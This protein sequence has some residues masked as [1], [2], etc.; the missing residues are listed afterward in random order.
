MFTMT[1]SSSLISILQMIHDCDSSSISTI[2]TL[3]FKA[4]SSPDIFCGFDQIKAAVQPALTSA[5]DGDTILRTLDLFS[6]GT[7]KDAS[8]MQQTLT[9]AQLL[10]LRMLTV[11]TLVERACL[12]AHGIVPYST[13]AQ[14]LSLE[15]DTLES[16]RQIEELMIACIYAGI[17]NG[18]LCQKTRSLVLSSTDGPPCR[19]R[20]VQNVSSMLK[21]LKTIQQNLFSTATSMEL[22][23]VNV[24]KRREVHTEFLKR[25]KEASASG[26]ST[27]A[28]GIPRGRSAAASSSMRRQA[29]KRSRGGPSGG[30][31]LMRT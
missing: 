16:N 19:P 29:G 21:S 11:V 7:Y 23:K 1:N 24:E 30:E 10:K 13:V 18:K 26:R 17:I 2:R 25:A 3:V 14:E 9:D 22:E 28:A 20:D 27:R 4:F 31:A 5:P 12:E 15:V 8:N 6:Y